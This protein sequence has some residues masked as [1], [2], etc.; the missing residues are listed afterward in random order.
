MKTVT[1]IAKQVSKKL[2]SNE[3]RGVA[4]EYP[5]RLDDGVSDEELAGVA[6]DVFHDNIAVANLDDFEFSVVD[7]KGK[8]IAEPDGYESYS[9]TGRGVLVL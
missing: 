6:L 4:G 5:V 2:D 1:V 9:G 7:A 3:D 8:E